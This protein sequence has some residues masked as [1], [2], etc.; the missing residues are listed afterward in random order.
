M[1]QA[2]NNLKKGD[3]VGIIPPAKSIDLHYVDQAVM[4]LESWGLQVRLS[5]NIGEKY[6]QFAGND[7]T[8]TKSFQD[9][10]DSEEMK[11]ILCAR[12]GYGTTRIIDSLNFEKFLSFP[13][14]IVGFSDITALLL[15]L[16]GLGYQGIHGP[17]P[18]NFSEPDA[19]ES[20]ERLR[21]LLF[22]GHI[23]PIHIEGNTYNSDG[24]V[25]G[26][27][28]GGN[29]SMLVNTL[30]TGDDFS[31]DRHILFIEEVDEYLYRI[32]RMFV[33][34]KR[35]GKLENLSALMIG[36]FTQVKD[37]DE[38]FGSGVEEIILDQV[39]GYNYPVCFG[40][41]FGHCMP[42]FP[43]I[44]GRNFRLEVNQKAAILS[45]SEY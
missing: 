44:L 25:S 42:N 31:T 2:P 30:G 41:P 28:I 26:K 9:F 20:I 21:R 24:I 14:W 37:N 29:L 18:F 6:Y 27:L 8:R 11:C 35:S 23:D 34:L 36:H 19:E 16:L 39:D 10:L 12:G 13:K 5:E 7:S 38:P 3:L 17:M 1:I 43:I 45:S 22:E 32:D 33:Q 15:H 40:A 4:I